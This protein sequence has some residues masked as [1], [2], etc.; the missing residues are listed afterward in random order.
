MWRAVVSPAEKYLDVRNESV[1]QRAYRLSLRRLCVY[2]RAF[3][4]LN[5]VPQDP[6]ARYGFAG[7]IVD[8]FRDQLRLPC[9]SFKT[10]CSHAPTSPPLTLCLAHSIPDFHFHYHTHSLLRSRTHSLTH[11]FTH[12]FT[13]FFLSQFIHSLTRTPPASAL[14]PAHLPPRSRGPLYDT[15]SRS[16]LLA[17]LRIWSDL[18]FWGV[19][20]TPPILSS[21]FV[22]SDVK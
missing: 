12:S 4:C 13:C 8:S 21:G 16:S 5:F 17:I 10:S 11:S 20:G 22:F 3:C 19:K 14:P 15:L 18:T 6:I 1:P 7:R 9:F 2:Q